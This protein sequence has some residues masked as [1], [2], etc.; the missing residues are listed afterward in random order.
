MSQSFPFFKE[1]ITKCYLY[2]KQMI[3]CLHS[4]EINFIFILFDRSFH[5]VSYSFHKIT[6]LV[7]L[8]AAQKLKGL[9]KFTNSVL[10]CY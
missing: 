5:R 2:V 7:I 10:K 3:H 4:K 6:F 8:S 9:Q 1:K